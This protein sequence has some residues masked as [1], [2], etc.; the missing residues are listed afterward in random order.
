MSMETHYPETYDDQQHGHDLV[1]VI[2]KGDELH[3]FNG[4]VCEA[5]HGMHEIGICDT[6]SDFIVSAWI[7]RD[8][9]RFGA[10]PIHHN[11]IVAV[12]RNGNCVYRMGETLPIQL[13]MFG[14]VA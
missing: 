4:T 13:E 8:G 6:E 14:D 5:R 11:A 12:W 7:Y 10:F 1:A 3:L 2:R 9:K